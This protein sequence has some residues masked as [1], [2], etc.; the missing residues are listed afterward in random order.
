MG[1]VLVGR[2]GKVIPSP[3]AL[4]VGSFLKPGLLQPLHPVVVATRQLHVSFRLRQGVVS[5]PLLE[6]RCGDAVEDGVPSVGVPEGMGVGPHGVQPRRDGRFF[7][8]LADPLPADVKERPGPVLRVD[9]RQVP[10]GSPPGRRGWGPRAPS[11]S[12]SPS[13]RA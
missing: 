13:P 12:C 11:C 3:P 4:L 10:Q 5:Q 9:R 7:H 8:G 1:Q 2:M 6:H